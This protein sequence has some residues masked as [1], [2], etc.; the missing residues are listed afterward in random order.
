M[1]II[2]LK[3]FIK[4]LIIGKYFLIQAY[5]IKIF[6]SYFFLWLIF[7]FFPFEIVK[8]YLDLNTKIENGVLYDIVGSFSFI[9]AIIVTFLVLILSILRDR[10]KRFALYELYQNNNIK[11]LITLTISV[12]IFNIFS[13][14]LIRKDSPS[15]NDINVAYFC[16]FSSMLYLIT[17]F[18][19][20]LKSIESVNPKEIVIRRISAL[21]INDFPEREVIHF[22]NIDDNPILILRNLLNASYHDNDISLVN[23]ILY[24]VTIKTC[25]I[26]SENKNNEVIS[27]KL[28]EGMLVIW[29]EYSA[30]SL[31]NRDNPNFVRIFECVE[32]MHI[33]FSKQKIPLIKLNEV[34]FY[35]KALL[36]QM[37][38]ENISEPFLQITFYIERIL[39]YHYE[40]SVPPEGELPHFIQYF[41]EPYLKTYPAMREYEFQGF[42]DPHIEGNIQWEKIAHEIPYYLNIILNESIDNKRKNNFHVIFRSLESLEI[43]V[44]K[45][46]LGKFQKRYIIRDLQG[47]HNYYQ[48]KAIENKIISNPIEVFLPNIDLVTECIDLKEPYVIKIIDEDFAFLKELNENEM[49]DLAQQPTIYF[50]AIGRHC[51][52]HIEK[53]SFYRQC[54]FYIIKKITELKAICEKGKYSKSNLQAIL[55]QVKSFPHYYNFHID[56]SKTEKTDT[57]VSDDNIILMQRI[58]EFEVL[59]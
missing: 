53:D 14:L 41:G 18:P 22:E 10:M 1:N 25:D 20:L 31:R 42:R 54:M 23:Q 24:S 11:A 56:L 3:R 7:Y 17:L 44:I 45:S 55:D 59:F 37:I 50:G 8:D 43:S 29:T 46:Q 28:I 34:D 13:L 5:S 6:L 4:K 16:V 33:H 32:Q 9:L 57:K 51:M 52:M 36:P 40:H 39:T 35:I 47:T 30:N 19:L 58:K 12:F 15:S 48:I 27:N 49:L 21:T 2:L 26:I 38:E